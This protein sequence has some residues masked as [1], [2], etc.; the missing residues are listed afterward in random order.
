MAEQ[1][2]PQ[3]IAS[4]VYDPNVRWV[5]GSSTDFTC[6]HCERTLVVSPSSLRHMR[7][8]P[9]EYIHLCAWCAEQIARV[10]GE[11]YPSDEM[12][13]DLVPGADAELRAAG[14]AKIADSDAAEVE[15][16]RRLFGS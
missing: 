10:W 8:V 3:I 14:L 7:A 11:L 9:G 6:W 15:R 12:R 1:N 13:V 2:P 4:P 16:I 5:P